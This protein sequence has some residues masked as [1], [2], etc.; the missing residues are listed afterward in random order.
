[1]SI[2]FNPDESPTTCA[3]TADSSRASVRASRRP[4]HRQILTQ[5]TLAGGL[6]LALIGILP[7]FLITGFRVAPIPFVG[8]WPDAACRDGLREGMGVKFYFGGTTLLIMVG[9]AMDTIIR[10]RR[11]SLCGTTTVS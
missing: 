7:D 11:N 6:Y 4:T 10:S 2:I 3:N 8:D 5:I 9:V 1:M